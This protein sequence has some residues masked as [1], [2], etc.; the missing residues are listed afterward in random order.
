MESSTPYKIFLYWLLLVSLMLFGGLVAWDTGAL[1]LILQ[2]DLTRI[3]AVILIV[4]FVASMH[5]AW[6]SF[7]LA[8]QALM[9]VRLQQ[10]LLQK[11]SAVGLLSIFPR[12]S[13]LAQEYLMGLYQSGDVQ[14]KVLLSEVMAESMRGAHQ[15]GWFI[16]GVIIKLGLLG[17][18]VGFVLMLGS[19]SGLDNLDISD[20]K[21]LMQQ[22][23]QGMG[24]AMNTTMVGLVCSMA[25]GLQYLLLDRCADRLVVEG[26]NLGQEYISLSQPEPIQISERDQTAGKQSES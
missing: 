11:G 18:V 14:D 16:A 19:V 8:R 23:T 5:C 26:V 10:E 15:V 21:Q 22:M 7:Y 13:C 2:Q 6:R 24:V 3:S 17:T 4:F 9:L 12:G 25:L 20:I 1:S